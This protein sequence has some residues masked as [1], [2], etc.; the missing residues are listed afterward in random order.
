VPD[1]SAE[2][3]A[4][5][6]GLRLGVPREHFFELVE[7]AVEERVRAAIDTLEG[8]G[9][10]IEEVSLPHATHAQVAGNV[11]MSVEAASWHEA[12]LRERAH[13]YGPDVLQRIRGG[14][15][16]RATEY[17]HSQRLRTLLQ[18]DFGAAFERVDVVL[19]PTMPLVAPRIGHT[20]E[21]GGPFNRS[22]RSIANR[23]TVPSNLTGMPAVSVPC[24]FADGLP[25]GLQVMGPAFGESIVLRVARAYE[26]AT[27]WSRQP[28]SFQTQAA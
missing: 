7:P 27:S 28:S 17:V 4:G 12:W 19:A 5:V 9:A 24:G 26:S 21:P 1:F 23:L 11:I 13:D 15:L 16:V 14:L 6:R 2:L 25:V 8:L 22:P 10:L 3:E 20:F 18:A